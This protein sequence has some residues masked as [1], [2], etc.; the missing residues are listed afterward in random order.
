MNKLLSNNYKKKNIEKF[1]IIPTPEGDFTFD[2]NTNTITKYNGIANNIIIPLKIRGINVIRIKNSNGNSAFNNNITS[3]SF[4]LDIN[5]KSYVTDISNN[6]FN[7]LS[8][9]T[10]IILPDSVTVIGSYAFRS[11]SSLNNITISNNIKSIGISAFSNCQNL[12]SIII[13]DKVTEIQGAA[14][15]NCK[16]LTSITF[17]GNPPNNIENE[18]FDE[19]LDTIPTIFYYKNKPKINGIKNYVDANNFFTVLNGSIIKYN[20]TYD[21]TLY[22]YSELYIPLQINN[23]NITS[24]GANVFAEKIISYNTRTRI[25]RV[26][27]ELNEFGKSNVTNINDSAFANCTKL[28][29]III[30]NGVNNINAYAFSNCKNLIYISVADSVTTIGKYAFY[31]TGLINFTIPQ[32]LN[33]M[34]YNPFCNSL[35]LIQFTIN[36]N[37]NYSV[38]NGVLY[39]NNN[40][41]LIAYPIGKKIE[42]YKIIDTAINIIEFSF[43]NCISLKNI[44]LPN[45]L[46]TIGT[47]AFFNCTGIT[48]IT[49]PNNVNKIGPNAFDNCVNLNNITFNG[50]CPDIGDEAFNN[51][52]NNIK[53]Y[54]NSWSYDDVNKFIKSTNKNIEF[55]DL[56]LITTY[57]KEFEFDNKTGT[58]TKYIGTSNDIIIPLTIGVVP[59]VKIKFTTCN[60]IKTINFE[61]DNNGKSNITTI[62][63]NVFAFCTS[64]TSIII[65][66]CINSIGANAF[67][68]CSKLTS[69]TIPD[70]VITIG[71]NAFNGCKNLTSI[72]FFGNP[73][74][75]MDTSIFTNISSNAT[76]FY[77]KNKPNINGI[78]NYV[79]AN[80][81][82]TISVLFGSIIKYNPTYNNKLY[83]FSE[84]Y[85]PLQINGKNIKSIGPNVFAENI[86]N[87][88]NRT[89]ITRVSFELDELRTSNVDT[90]EMHAFS[91]CINL[92]NFYIPKSIKTLSTSTDTD[93]YQNPFYNCISLTKFTVDNNNSNYSSENGVLFNK[94]KTE[95]IQYP[96]GNLNAEYQIP[97][98][99]TNI[100]S[101]ALAST[102]LNTIY[103]PEGV[104]ILSSGAFMRIIN[105]YNIIIP[106]SVTLIE[107]NCFL[108]CPRL[109]MVVFKGD[110]P[111]MT[112]YGQFVE[113]AYKSSLMVFHYKQNDISVENIF[114]NTRYTFG[115]KIIIINLKCYD[116]I[117]SFMTY[118]GNDEYNGCDKLTSIVIE[119]KV[120]TIGDNAFNGCINLNKIMFKGKLPILGKDAFNNIKD[121]AIVYYY[122][123]TKND[124]SKFI[125]STNK[126]I[127]FKN[128]TLSTKNQQGFNNIEYFTNAFYI[129][130]GVVNYILMVI[131]IILIIYLILNI[132]GIINW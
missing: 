68:G 65:P 33:L 98:S 6:V 74:N 59:V 100:K 84:L 52:N 35:Q 44:I 73:P 93:N 42:S 124:E 127:S 61:L 118:I 105:L 26:L 39:S 56:N 9:L 5:G 77:Y 71:A 10:S 12:N 29:N 131:I 85:I 22:N 88:N 41:N 79:D 115:T 102:Q 97:N 132:K 34:E 103:I 75:N 37:N 107:G 18:V 47:S 106:K 49:I 81:F 21:G 53:V 101:Y 128:L 83:N 92:K 62:E 55:I 25:V 17:F 38:D 60:N 89:R 104:K 2:T 20:P 112:S 11:C 130:T 120:K 69:I 64:L 50:P 58:I 40:K 24:I 72:T 125:N 76:I 114:M 57:K 126:K 111:R 63:D 96:I 27:F 122:S 48:S 19:D 45:T 7:N 16:K 82:Y 23:Q 80:N 36:N 95:L 54:Y 108:R 78:N 43:Y 123:W 129:S 110:I 32:N 86:N 90:I 116:V 14:F 1:E 46:L 99:V 91:N 113:V 31:N 4:Q 30:P 8:N 109:N 87:I 51:I 94:N 117:P 3:I 119:D 66:D 121:N 13:P 15:L 67:N 70:K 28:T